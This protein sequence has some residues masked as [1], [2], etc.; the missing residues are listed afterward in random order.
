M[1]VGIPDYL[2]G[3]YRHQSSIELD[4]KAV[5][6]LFNE[7]ERVALVDTT[8][9]SKSDSPGAEAGLCCL[10]S[11]TLGISLMGI[12]RPLLSITTRMRMREQI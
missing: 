11:A 12:I 6:L 3:T 9:A 4:R 7:N 8:G 2:S 10:L 1:L 5:I